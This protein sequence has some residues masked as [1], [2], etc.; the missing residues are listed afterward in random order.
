MLTGTSRANCLTT[1]NAAS[2]L[3]NIQTSMGDGGRRM[4][5]YELAGGGSGRRSLSVQG[6]KS[7]DG[8]MQRV[9]HAD[10]RYNDAGRLNI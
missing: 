2:Y 6:S 9:K 5:N 7:L 1:A 10:V 8:A 3:F 4:L